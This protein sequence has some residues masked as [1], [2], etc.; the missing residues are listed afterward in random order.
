MTVIEAGYPVLES[1]LELLLIPLIFISNINT[2]ACPSG[3]GIAGRLNYS[4]SKFIPSGIPELVILYVIG[5]L[6]C[7]QFEIR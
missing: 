4:M 5:N 6:V 3:V 2:R 7:S 1:F